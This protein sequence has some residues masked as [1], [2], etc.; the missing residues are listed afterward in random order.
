MLSL[1]SHVGDV[2]FTARLLG[3][4]QWH[5]GMGQS[6]VSL[7]YRDIGRCGPG[8]EVSQ[9]HGQSP[10]LTLLHHPDTEHEQAAAAGGEL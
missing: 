5:A 4:L 7:G 6:R 2:L 8:A 10:V 1:V 3:S 9:C